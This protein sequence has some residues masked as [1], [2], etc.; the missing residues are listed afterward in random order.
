MAYGCKMQLALLL[1]CLIQGLQVRQQ[2]SAGRGRPGLARTDCL[3]QQIFLRCPAFC[4]AFWSERCPIWER[5]PPIF[6]VLQLG[7]SR[8]FVGSQEG[9][10]FSF[11]KL[12]RATDGSA[13]IA[14]V[15]RQPIGPDREYASQR[16]Q[17]MSFALKTMGSA[18][19]GSAITT[20][21]ATPI[22]FL[23]GSL[24]DTCCP[25]ET[26]LFPPK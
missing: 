14:E 6:E 11:I 9:D 18:T 22:K 17:R 19:M 24:K 1:P 2:R 10:F 4:P 13:V 25:F 3:S 12:A 7:K 16:L 26:W 5:T 20:A 23:Q 21:G 8:L 15:D